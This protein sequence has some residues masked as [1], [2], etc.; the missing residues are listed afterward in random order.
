M[1]GKSL[2]HRSSCRQ[3]RAAPKVLKL[4]VAYVLTGLAGAAG[5]AA[6]DAVAPSVAAIQAAYERE[7]VRSQA[8][9]DKDLEVMSADC[10]RAPSG[11]QHLC[12]ITYV[13]RSDPR[14]ALSYDVAALEP[15]V[16]GWVL[17]GGL[18]KK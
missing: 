7:A 16:E 10:S 17:K 2:D 1:A 15:S 6:A 9:H 4:G 18:C 5:P 14:R 3:R 13:T 8:R 11:S 12:W